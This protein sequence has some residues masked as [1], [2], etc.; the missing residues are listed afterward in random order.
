MDDLPKIKKG[1]VLVTEMTNPDMVV[2]MQKSTAI[3]TDEGGMTAH[4]SIVSREM[5]IP[6]VVGTNNATSVLKDGMKITVD[7]YRG[8]IYEGEIAETHYA[9]VK[10]ASET[11]RIKLKL[12]IYFP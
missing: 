8:L 2:A 1:E 5:G 12:I 9:E 4:A 6:A 11:K 10:Q 7:G 3:V